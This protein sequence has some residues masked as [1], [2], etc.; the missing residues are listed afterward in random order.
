[1]NRNQ[2]RRW[3]QLPE[4]ARLHHSSVRLV[5]WLLALIAIYMLISF[6]GLIVQGYHMEQQAA[7]M[8]TEIALL[9]QEQRTL[10][11]RKGY[12]QSASAVDR[13]AREQLDMAHPDDV[14]LQ[15]KVVELPTPRP[16]P[17][18]A[19]QRVTVLVPQS[20]TPNWRRWW[21]ALFGS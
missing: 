17:V 2:F 1:M 6:V 12:V 20:S 3:P 10:E 13:L 18:P 5:C 19:A 7:Q 8:Q 9:E 11:G 21:D 14:V 15:L 4:P 16:V